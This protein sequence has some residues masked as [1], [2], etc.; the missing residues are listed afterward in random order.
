MEKIIGRKEELAVLQ[1]LAQSERAEF[2]AVYGRRRVGKT[3]LISQFFKETGIY[4]EITGSKDAS[5]KEQIINFHREF[6]ALFKA[7]EKSSLP[8]S[9]SEAFDLLKQEIIKIPITQKIILFFDELPWLSTPKSGFLSALEY[10]W[11]RHAS[12]MPNVVIIICGS[13]ASWM[14]KKVINNR[15]GLYGRLSAEIRLQPFSLLETEEFFLDR[16]I[17]LTRKQI[18]EIYMVTGG[19]PKYLSCVEKAQ[20]ST[21]T[22]NSLCFTPQGPLLKE[23]HKLY[24]SLFENAYRHVKIVAALAYKREG[25][26]QKDLFKLLDIP[27]GGRS[28]E[29]LEELIESGFITSSQAYGKQIKERKFRLI[30]EYSLFYLTWI[31]SMKENI[32]RGSE[33]YWIKTQAT[34][35]WYPWAGYAFENICLKHILKIKEALAIGG[36]STIASHWQ[37]SPLKDERG[38]EVDLV[39][40]RA[41]D[42]INLCEIKFCNSEYVM[43]K[44]DSEDLERKKNVFKEKTQ[45]KKAIFTTLITPYGALENIHYRSSVHNQLTLDCFFKR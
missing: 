41:D 29:I 22:I 32:L 4:F 17:E 35:S 40:D 8:S 31:D 34:P 1:R 6:R 42:C 24:S 39:I 26:T 16:R 25:M 33:D 36:V 5:K 28:S 9:W 45:T 7:E 27:Q 44:Q 21:Q 14:I 43:S 20:S 19:I 30:D 11:N 12:R 37:Y 18:T 3:F 23:F 10:F 13:A 38:A 2:V 15:G